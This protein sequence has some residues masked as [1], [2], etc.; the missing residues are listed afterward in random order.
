MASSKKGVSAHQIHRALGITY[1]SA[2]FLMHRIREAMTDDCAPLGGEGKTLEIDETYQGYVEGGPTWILHPQYDWQKQRAW[3]DKRKVVTLVERGGKARSIKVET[4]TVAEVRKVVLENADT[5]RKLITD[6]AGVYRRLGRQFA[7]HETINHEEKEWRRGDAHTNTV[8]VFLDLQA[9]DDRC[10]S[11]LRRA[12]PSP[13][14]RRVRFP[15]LQPR[16]TRG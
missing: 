11:A 10:L 5:A 12:A 13:L 7:S 8:E 4:V 16:Q 1:K 15:L 9:R 2:W 14:S 3:A 6:Q